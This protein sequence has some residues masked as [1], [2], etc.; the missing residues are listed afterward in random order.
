ML[1]GAPDMAAMAEQAPVKAPPGQIFTY[2]NG[3][4][5]LL[6]RMIRDQV[7]GSAGSVAAFAHRELFDKLG[8]QHM[9]MEFD[10]TGTPIGST[11]F[12]ASA[13]DWARFG[14]LF[15]NDGVV[16]GER[17]LPEGWMDYSARFTPGSEQIGYGAGFWTNRGRGATIRARVAGGMPADSFYASGVYGQTTL[18][19]PAEHLVIVRLGVSY[20]KWNDYAA[21]NRLVAE[22]VTALASSK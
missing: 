13:R 1:Y 20:T 6:S 18:I 9:L 21:A 3:N 11:S 22:T 15:L 8:M 17:I 10:A 2:S 4:T 5:L 12:Y 7:G 16:G 14:L 19:A